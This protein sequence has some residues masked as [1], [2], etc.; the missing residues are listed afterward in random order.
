ML[1]LCCF[2]LVWF[3]RVLVF[4]VHV[5]SCPDCVF[6]AVIEWLSLFVFLCRLFRK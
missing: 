4:F 6:D 1:L 3:L 2:L 5:Y